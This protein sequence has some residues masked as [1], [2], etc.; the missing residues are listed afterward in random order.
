[1]QECFSGCKSRRSVLNCLDENP[2]DI[3]SAVTSLPD[4]L[5]EICA[6][7]AEGVNDKQDVFKGILYFQHVHLKINYPLFVTLK[8]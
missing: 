2:L 5:D 7:Q 6:A 1:M 4:C 3:L 8:S